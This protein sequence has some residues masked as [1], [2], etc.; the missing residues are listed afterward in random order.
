MAKTKAVSEETD[1]P[2]FESALRELET[3]VGRLEMGGDT[4]E[5]A[6]VDYSQAIE[7]LKSCHGRL[8]LAE[9]RVELLSGVDAQGNPVTAPVAESEFSLE[10]KTQARGRRRTALSGDQAD[11]LD[12][13]AG[14]R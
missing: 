7:L 9:R 8:E 10:Q 1:S 13:G 3:I 6:L 4:L 11:D 14:R 12:D 5:Q 2:D